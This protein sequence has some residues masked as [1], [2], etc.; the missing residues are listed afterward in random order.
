MSPKKYLCIQRSESGECDPPSPDQMQEMMAKFQ[1]WMKKFEANIVDLGGK[2][3][4]GG[5]VNSNGAVD[6]PVTESKGVI[7]G[8][9]IVAAD[10][11]EEAMQIAQESPG[12]IMP[13]STVEVR[14]IST[15]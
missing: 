7:G 3:G 13:G 6:D 8:Y 1:A 11:L 5:V 2:L 14:E 10:S 12:G 4:D 9:M 15:P